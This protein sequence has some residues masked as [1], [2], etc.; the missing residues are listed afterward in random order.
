MTKFTHLEL[1]IEAQWQNSAGKCDKD[2]AV[3]L[4]SIFT[5]LSSKEKYSVLEKQSCI[6]HH[7][8]PSNQCCHGMPALNTFPRNLKECEWSP[9]AVQR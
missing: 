1:L 8:M 2:L 9:P 6:F 5:L 3:F 4:D 7:S